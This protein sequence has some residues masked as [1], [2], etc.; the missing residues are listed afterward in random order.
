MENTKELTLQEKSTKRANFCLTVTITIV[1]AYLMLLYLGQTVQNLITVRKAIIV[2]IMLAIPPVISFFFYKTNSIS[3]LYRN[4]ALVSY[5][6]VFEIACLSSTKFY[7]NFFLLPILISMIMYF[8]Y[9]LFLFL[10]QS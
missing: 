6:F 4:V 10:I 7:Y 2:A 9:L 8:D 1:S 3:R 5:L